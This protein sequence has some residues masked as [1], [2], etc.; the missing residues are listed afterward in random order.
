[1]HRSLSRA[2][3]LCGSAALALAFAACGDD[4]PATAVET[5]AVVLNN[6]SVTPALVKSLVAG[7]D[8][9]SLVSSDDVLPDSPNFIFGGSAD[10]SGLIKNSDG[11]FTALVNNEDNYSISRLTFDNTFKPIK[12]E[13]V[14][15]STAGKY[16]MCSAT[17][18]TL[19]EHGFGPLYL[20]GGETNEE[21]QILAVNPSGAANTPT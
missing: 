7:V 17:M 20:A 4:E 16:R 11:T 5:S 8:I 6:R 19:A 2:A 13:Y 10:G 12:G 3:G 14:V 15:N 18:V 21:S 1:M 9:Y